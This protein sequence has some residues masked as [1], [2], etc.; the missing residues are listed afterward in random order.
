MGCSIVLALAMAAAAFAVPAF[1]VPVVVIYPLTL[2][3]AVV[4]SEV[5]SDVSIILGTRLAQGG[6]VT[7]LPY[8]PGTTRSQYLEAAIK[9]NADYYVTGYLQQLGPDVSMILQVVSTHSGSVVFSNTTTI[10][11]FGDAAAQA[12]PLRAA[13]LRHAGRGL[14]ALDAPPPASIPTAEP[15]ANQGVNLTRALRRRAKAAP[16]PSSAPSSDAGLVPVS[17]IAASAANA[18]SKPAVPLLT[19]APLHA[20]SP[21][22]SPTP[23]PYVSPTPSP[24]PIATTPFVAIAHKGS[25][26][27]NAVTTILVIDSSGTES[28]DARARA[29]NSLVAA[30]RDLGF[31][32]ARL[33]IEASQATANARSIC[34]ANPGIERFYE[35]TVAIRHNALGQS[36]ANIVVTSID[37]NGTFAAKREATSVGTA[38]GGDTSAID[39]AAI[40]VAG[41]LD[42][43]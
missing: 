24:S 36:L 12:D 39:R 11:T 23:T 43:V 17:E 31:P 8:T 33:A 37:C 28:V 27:A 14:A 1:A 40:V 41:L 3:G 13:I 34:R 22:P 29:S 26:P 38:S 10:K 32:A 4:H 42:G 35:P 9:E 18:S 5:G 30:L 15:T 6:N 20:P 16:S 7:V 19:P 2:S 25:I 21:T